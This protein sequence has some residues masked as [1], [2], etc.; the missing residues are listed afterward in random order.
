[1]RL[2]VR[3]GSAFL[4]ASEKA[5]LAACF[6]FLNL[7]EES[8]VNNDKYLWHTHNTNYGQQINSLAW[9]DNSN[10]LQ[11]ICFGGS[12]GSRRCVT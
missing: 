2:S 5:P 8:V 11:R 3:L 4:K 9:L 6:S 7:V 12:G 1:M 10:D